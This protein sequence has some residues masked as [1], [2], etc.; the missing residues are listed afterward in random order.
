MPQGNVGTPLSTF[1]ML[2]RTCKLPG[3]V[4]RKLQLE[5]PKSRSS[6]RYGAVRF[7]YGGGVAEVSA[8]QDESCGSEDNDDADTVDPE[9]EDIPSVCLP[10]SPCL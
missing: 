3:H 1:M 2:I 5:F 4:I 10:S 6:K 9:R 7:N 8:T